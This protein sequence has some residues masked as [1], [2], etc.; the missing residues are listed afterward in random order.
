[1]GGSA[2][3][4]R[5]VVS[6]SAANIQELISV[7][8]KRWWTNTQIWRHCAVC[9]LLPDKVNLRPH[10]CHCSAHSTHVGK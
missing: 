10:A 9:Y 8:S 2:I 6:I 4:Q 7:N 1:M 5:G 3:P